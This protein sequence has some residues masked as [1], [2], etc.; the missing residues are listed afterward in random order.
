MRPSLQLRVALAALAAL[1]FQDPAFAQPRGE[2][3]VIGRSIEMHSKLYD[4]DVRLSVVLPPGYAESRDRYPVLYSLHTYFLHIAGSVE[5]LSRG[6]IP[7]MIYVHLETYSSGDLI[8]TP[9]E[10]R[11]GSGGADRLIAFF[12]DELIPLIDENYRTQPF[13]VV[14][15]SSWGG[16]FCLYTLLTQP[17]VFNGYIAATPWLIYDG[18]E[19]YLLE[20]AE[21]LL[22]SRSFAHNFLFMAIGND[23]DPGLHEG[24]EVLS[25]ILEDNPK[26][27]LRVH[28]VSWPDEDHS[29]IAHKAVYD[30]LKWV[31]R[32]WREMP[33]SVLSG[34]VS[35]VRRYPPKLLALYGYD[36]GINP[37]SLGM[38]A[39]RLKG[40]EKYE[41]AIEIRRYQIELSPDSPY[42]HEGLARTYEASGQFELALQSFE[43]ARN[44]ARARSAPDLGRFEDHILRVRK[45]IPE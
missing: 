26:Q 18:E 7:K 43:T 21:G 1:A 40:E 28:H 20:H 11:P 27:G 39:N 17:A 22:K 13:R 8:P 45:K 6:Q 36:I 33:E 14:L 24:F 30:G 12:K 31:F 42:L 3:I 25:R 34:G 38:L 19:R 41:Q 44:L 10:T 16:V 32:D 15:S 9:I 4:T 29:S 2:D 23:P 37:R 35:A 5:Q